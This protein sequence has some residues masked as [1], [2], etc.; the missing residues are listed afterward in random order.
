MR[1]VLIHDYDD[2]D[3]QR[4]WRA[5]Q[6]DIRPLVAA[7]EAYLAAHPTEGESC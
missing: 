1:N 7:I 3:P 2:V 5:T 4:V 6:E